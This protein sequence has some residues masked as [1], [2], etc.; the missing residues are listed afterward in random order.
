VVFFIYKEVVL[1]GV[2]FNCNSSVVC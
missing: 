1:F 2:S